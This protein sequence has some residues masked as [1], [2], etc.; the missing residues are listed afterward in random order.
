MAAAFAEDTAGSDVGQPRV[1]P[2]PLHEPGCTPQVGQGELA[3]KVL[4]RVKPEKSDGSRGPATEYLVRPTTTLETLMQGWC[5]ARGIRLSDVKFVLERRLLPEE[6][7]QDV[8]NSSVLDV[9]V[10]KEPIPAPLWV[11]M[12]AAMWPS[13]TASTTPGADRGALQGGVACPAALTEAPIVNATANASLVSTSYRGD[14]DWGGWQAA[15][16]W[17]W[18]WSGS[19]SWGAECH[20]RWDRQPWSVA[21]W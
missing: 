6:N 7:L 3:P 1:A 5:K 4:V 15:G 21:Q 2:M 10:V 13:A 18:A 9:I 8:W 12:S 17:S 20:D 14:A 11:T 19:W 16:Q